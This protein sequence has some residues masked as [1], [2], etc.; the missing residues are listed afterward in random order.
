MSR[1]LS[2]LLLPLLAAAT[3]AA[4][5]H[6]ELAARMSERDSASEYWDLMARFESGHSLLARFLVTN[7]GPGKHTAVAIGHL[8]FP[9]GDHVSFRNGRER[10]RWKLEEDGM[11]LDVGSSE[12]DL[13][14]PVR[15]YDIDKDRDGIHIHLSI[16]ASA[17]TSLVPKTGPG[18]YGMR[19][20]DVAA[21][22]EGT[23][24]VR[25]R[26]MKEPLA[27]RG[28]ASLTQTW[29]NTRESAVALRRIDFASLSSDG[30]VSLLD[31]TARNDTHLRWLVVEREGRIVH[32]S[33]DFQLFLEGEQGGDRYP[34]P[35]ALRF[36]DSSVQ[37][38][39]ELQRIVLSHDP[40]EDLPQ[41]F[42]FLLSFR[43]RP[44]RIWAESPFEVKFDSMSDRS[45]WEV[46]GTGMASVTWLNPLEP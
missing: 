34:L 25:D 11:R 7:E 46:H 40:L 39:V 37:G 20:L 33:G 5:E 14:G 21:P 44:R 27:V 36:S 12:L 19:I 6:S 41:P 4:G 29:V 17:A 8:I 24:Q 45:S 9:N 26:A 2:I 31:M 23:L 35:S 38:R 30:A 42:R 10:A 16:H 28:R 18:G 1:T 43:T 22:V 13:R 32:Q 15:R 3:A